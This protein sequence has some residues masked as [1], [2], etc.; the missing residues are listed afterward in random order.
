MSELGKRLVSLISTRSSTQEADP[1]FDLIHEVM[2]QTDRLNLADVPGRVDRLIKQ[3][4]S[5]ERALAAL[6][7]ETTTGRSD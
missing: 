6:E 2:R 1:E 3:H 5:A 7:H 4:G